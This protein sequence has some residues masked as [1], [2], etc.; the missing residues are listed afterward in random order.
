MAL[1]VTHDV[2][3]Q[4]DDEGRARQL[5]HP[6]RP[7]TFSES[8]L[9]GIPSPRALADQYLQQIQSL[10]NLPATATGN[11]SFSLESVPSDAG[12]DLRF[13][14]EKKTSDSAA[15]TYAQARFGIP[16]W[17]A[18]LTV[19]MRTQPLEVTGAANAVHY[20]LELPEPSRNA[21]Y[22]PEKIDGRNLPDLFPPG[23]IRDASINKRRLWIYKFDPDERIDHEVRAKPPSVAFEQGPPTLPLFPLPPSIKPAQHYVVTE[24]LFTM[25]LPNWGKLNWRTFVEVETG[26]VLY[27]RVCRQWQ[28]VSLRPGDLAWRRVFRACDRRRAGRSARAGSPERRG[29]RSAAGFDEAER[30]MGRSGRHTAARRCRPDRR[31]AV[32]FQV[33]RQN[34]PLRRGQRLPSLR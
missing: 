11:L 14:E 18:G 10:I 15:V 4:K 22:L 13:K 33:L 30:T 1:E 26:A 32:R 31:G 28:C 20:D 17:N 12:M 9:E 21:A 2:Q 19:R 8:G 25:A 16:V 5:S 34:R 24:V 27:V 3:I 29:P 23:V 7:F 6:L